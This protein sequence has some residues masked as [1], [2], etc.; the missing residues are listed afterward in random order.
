VP[1]VA[2]EASALRH[3]HPGQASRSNFPSAEPADQASPFAALVDGASD[4]SPAPTSAPPAPPLPPSQKPAARPP[5]GH[6]AQ[7]ASAETAP[8]PQKPPSAGPAPEN[9]AGS[10]PSSPPKGADGT[11]IAATVLGALA[12]KAAKDTSPT[13]DTNVVTPVANSATDASA[14]SSTRDATAGSS[15]VAAITDIHDDKTAKP[16]SGTSDSAQAAAPIPDLSANQLIPVAPPPIA[17]PLSA[18]VIAAAP[19]MIG[20]G[21]GSDSGTGQDAV[22]IAAMGDAM[23]GALR[24]QAD[25]AAAKS[26][27][28]TTDTS[29]GGGS[30]PGAKKADTATTTPALAPQPTQK[31]LISAAS[32]GQANAPDGAGSRNG[33]AAAN[34]AATNHARQRAET[35]QPADGTAG[36]QA[37][38]NG[39]SNG[40][41]NVDPNLDPKRDPVASANQIEDLTR[42][43]LDPTARRVEAPATETAGAGTPHSGSLEV[44]SATQSPDGA[45]GMA[46]PAIL[47]TAAAPTSAVMTTATPIAIPIAG[48]AVEIASHARAG[49]N[50]FEIRLDP[51]ELGRIDVRLDVDREGKVTSRLVVDRPETLDMLR[52][53]APA[54]ERSLQ[55]AGLKTADNALQFSLRDQG[56]FG[57]QNPYPN[58][59]SSAAP[60]RV[61][62]PDREL[63]PVAATTAG[64]GRVIGTTS[65]GVDIRV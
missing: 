40:N 58:N 21:T 51:P 33:A 29:S 55:Q 37:D 32:A 13:I 42:Q 24:G 50:R 44:G 64:Y 47:T 18:P 23:A 1:S 3:A 38:S 49:K 5:D 11:A 16:D 59:G 48:L 36:P 39:N 15:T 10:V 60:T 27:S 65:A 35:S 61:I 52:R 9:Q 14:G 19:T 31:D 43:A 28:A 4:P 57:G 46:A 41:S 2:S 25:A 63:P 26:G 30:K 34:E 56:G 7:S 8:G 20:S 22:Q 45:G 54:L 62:I 12:K 6:A 53:D 17:V